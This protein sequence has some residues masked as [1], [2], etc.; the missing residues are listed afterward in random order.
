VNKSCC[1]CLALWVLVWLHAADARAREHKVSVD[2]CTLLARAIYTE[3][4]SSVT[5]GPGKSGPWLID[6]GQG[7]VV[8]CDHVARTVS[9]AFTSA[10][11]SAGI[12]VTWQSAARSSNRLDY[13]QHSFLSRCYP[14]RHPSSD[15]A[16]G[17]NNSV[18]QE[19]WTIVARSVMREMY[20]P[21]SSDEVS[22]RGNDLKL[23]LGLS[24]RTIDGNKR[25]R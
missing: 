12:E 25:S 3:V 4:S 24:L 11:R 20:N 23:R 6:Q 19:T 8:Y 14:D 10:M 18:V 2:G 7:E 17:V 9:R 15:L 13:C 16:A 22:F 5:H 21:M 1:A